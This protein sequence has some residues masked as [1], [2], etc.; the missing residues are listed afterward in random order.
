MERRQDNK[1]TTIVLY[2]IKNNIYLYIMVNIYNMLF[3][4]LI[5]IYIIYLIKGRIIEKY[6]NYTSNASYNNRDLMYKNQKYLKGNKRLKKM[7]TRDI[8]DKG[9]IINPYYKPRRYTGDLKFRKGYTCG[10]NRYNSKW[11]KLSN[12]VNEKGCHNLCK[13]Y[14]NDNNTWG[15]CWRGLRNPN[16]CYFRNKSKPIYIGGHTTRSAKEMWQWDKKCSYACQECKEYRRSKGYSSKAIKNCELLDNPK[17][18]PHRYVC[19][20]KKGNIQY[21]YYLK[22]GYTCDFKSGYKYLGKYKSNGECADACSSYSKPGC[23][24]YGRN[25]KYKQKCYLVNNKRAWP[26]GSK[27]HRA[28]AEC[29]KQPPKNILGQFKFYNWNTVKKKILKIPGK[30]SPLDCRK[31]CLSDKNCSG[32]ETCRPGKGCSGCYLFKNKIPTPNTVSDDQLFGERVRILR[33]KPKLKNSFKLLKR[34]HFNYRPGSYT[35]LYAYNIKDCQ[36]KCIKKGRSCQGIAFKNKNKCIH[37]NYAKPKGS[38][39]WGYKYYIRQFMDKFKY[40]RGGRCSNKPGVYTRFKGG[41]NKCKNECI[42]RGNKCQGISYKGNKCFIYEYC[43]PVRGTNW[44]YRYYYRLFSKKL[45]NIKVPK[46]KVTGFYHWKHGHCDWRGGK[47][48]KLRTKNIFDCEKKC[49]RK[50]VGCRAFA[51]KKGTCFHYSQC[52]PKRGSNWGYKYYIRNF[53][54]SFKYINRGRCSNIPKSH[55]R[56]TGGYK[57]CKHEC[58]RRGNDC[59]GI[60]YKGNRCFIYKRCNP[61]RGTNWGYRYYYRKY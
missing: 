10:I 20:Q 14:M 36:N 48:K 30:I 43:T 17:K 61:I 8:V 25:G 51:Y 37:Y 41:Y 3:I 7:S 33:N 6:S 54:N 1:N 55:V 53:I 13:K 49:E 58:K 35:R 59:Q 42:K 52:K 2:I 22:P 16:K 34:G 27:K 56:Y 26:Y 24:W 9:N 46:R 12:N 5:I 19:G 28:A 45:N 50:G 39:N 15:C 38:V 44:G 29:Y 11:K 4:L 23:C 57:K 18:T 40:I 21:R 32:W 60:S 31:K 47:Y